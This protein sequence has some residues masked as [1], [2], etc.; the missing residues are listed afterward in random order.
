MPPQGSSNDSST[1]QP[2][3]GILLTIYLCLWIL[4]IPLNSLYLMFLILSKNP[5]IPNP[6][7]I[8]L[9][10]FINIGILISAILLFFWHKIGAYGFIV[11]P[12]VGLLKSMLFGHPSDQ[13]ISQAISLLIMEGILLLLLRNKWIHL[14]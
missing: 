12:I 2:N 10:I 13:L 6:N 5:A 4:F 14:K 1:L 3:R 9:S 7:D 11:L 8:W